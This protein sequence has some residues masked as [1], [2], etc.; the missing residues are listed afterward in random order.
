[1]LSSGGKRHSR[2]GEQHCQ[3]HMGRREEPGIFQELNKDQSGLRRE[4]EEKGEAGGVSRDWI[5]KG[6]CGLH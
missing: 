6:P 5:M 4:I 3:G 2:K 1:M